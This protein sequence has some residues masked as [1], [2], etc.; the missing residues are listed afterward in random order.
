MCLLE[1][2]KN[3]LAGVDGCFGWLGLVGVKDGC[4]VGLAGWLA[5]VGFMVVL[6]CGLVG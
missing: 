1:K 4:L 2:N 3:M 5:W 6:V